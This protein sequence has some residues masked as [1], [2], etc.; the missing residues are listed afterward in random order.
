MTWGSR[1]NKGIVLGAIA[2]LGLALGAC[3][4]DDDDAGGEATVGNINVATQPGGAAA[5]GGTITVVMTDNKYTPNK[6]EVEA[7]KE[8]TFV[9]KNQGA[10]VHN[11]KI[12]SSKT[13]GKDFASDALVNPEKESKFTV[14]FTKKGTVKF[15]CD[16]HLPDMA[17]EIVVK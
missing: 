11:M 4:S 9:A 3:A 1:L 13:E 5:S 7:G 10:A 2:V 15:Q 12:L 17:G 6:I 16:Y 8:I 14:T